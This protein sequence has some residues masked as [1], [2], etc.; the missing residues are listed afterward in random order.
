M[1]DRCNHVAANTAPS[2]A[3]VAGSS[4]PAA[5]CIGGQQQHANAIPLSNLLSRRSSF[6][7]TEGDFATAATDAPD[8]NASLSDCNWNGSNGTGNGNG[9]GSS[10]RK[11]DTAVLATSSMI[12]TPRYRGGGYRR[13]GGGSSR[14]GSQS[15]HRM[16]Q[17]GQSSQHR[18]FGSQEEYGA[19]HLGRL[20]ASAIR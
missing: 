4:S 9:G 19:I 7:V 20:Q 3:V 10:H 16:G 2:V 8:H 13:E 15:D 14:G 12:S 17:M 6:T 1:D 11:V 18:I 5:R